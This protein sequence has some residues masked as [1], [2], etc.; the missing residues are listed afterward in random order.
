MNTA[1]RRGRRRL[2]P[3]PKAASSGRR[4]GGVRRRRRRLAARRPL[5][6]RDRRQ[7]CVF[8][9]V[10]DLRLRLRR[11]RRRVAV[12]LEGVRRDAVLGE[13]LRE[14]LAPLL[15]Y[16]RKAKRTIRKK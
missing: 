15:F 14:L 11:R 16:F 7:D 10:V 2:P 6:A 13:P 4:G 9:L 1:S 5:V 12:E 8:E 3:K